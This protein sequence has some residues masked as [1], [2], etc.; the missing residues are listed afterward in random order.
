MGTE[1]KLTEIFSRY[2]PSE[3]QREILLSAENVRLRADR[4]SRMIE[5]H[6]SFPR[7]ITKLK[8]YELEVGIAEAYQLNSVRIL[9]HYPAECFNE[10]YISQILIEAE[11]VA[12]GRC[13]TSSITNVTGEFFTEQGLYNEIKAVLK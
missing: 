9:P 4:A 3:D 12:G 10:S 6:A 13:V 2:S 5:I 1:K 8:L 11:R 7:P